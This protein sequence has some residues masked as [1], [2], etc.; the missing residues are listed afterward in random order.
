MAEVEWVSGRPAQGSLR[1]ALRHALRRTRPELRVVAEDFLAEATPID[2][3]A[4][5]P[6][7]ELVSVRVSAGPEHGEDGALLVRGLSDLAWLRPRIAD[8][9]KLAPD[10]G[11]ERTA[12]PRALLVCPRFGSEVQTATHA[13]STAGGPLAGTAPLELLEYRPLQQRGQLTLLLEPPQRRAPFVFDRAPGAFVEETR[14]HQRL[15]EPPSPSTFRT[16]LSDADLLLDPD[17]VVAAGE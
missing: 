14:S 11:L 3:L 2:L 8:L 17:G 13:L 9:A 6:A 15:T 10:L 7:G 4:I 1:R 5:G 16:G 12:P